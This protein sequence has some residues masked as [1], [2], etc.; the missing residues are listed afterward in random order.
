LE[1]KNH[2]LELKSLQE[3]G[4]FSGYASVFNNVDL[5]G[6]VVLPGAFGGSLKGWSRLGKMPK[7]LWQHDAS[8][9]IGAWTKMVEDGYGLYV[10]GKIMLS[11]EKGREAYEFLKCGAVDGLSIGYN[12]V[13]SLKKGRARELVEL[14]LQEV[15]L[16]TFAA[17]PKARIERFK[18]LNI[19]EYFESRI[20]DICLKINSYS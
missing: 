16:V 2:S 4:S 3:D 14:D 18:K 9:P 7:M 20:N 10:G 8:Q 15:S 19:N 13:R 5:H 6:E 11:A 17:N 12:V 1:L